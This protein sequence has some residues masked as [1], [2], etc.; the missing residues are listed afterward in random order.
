MVLLVKAPGL[1]TIMLPLE[2]TGGV[3]GARAP[4]CGVG[5]ASLKPIYEKKN[6][7][8]NLFFLL[9]KNHFFSKNIFSHIWALKFDPLSYNFIKRILQLKGCISQLIGKEKI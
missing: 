3:W 9:K 4:Q 7:K 2:L 5:Y 6:R 1:K 8:K